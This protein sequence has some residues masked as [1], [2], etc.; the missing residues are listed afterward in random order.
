[1]A[2]KSLLTEAEQSRRLTD[3]L[4]SIFPDSVAV[5]DKDRWYAA[6]HRVRGQELEAVAGEHQTFLFNVKPQKWPSK[7]DHTMAHLKALFCLPLASSASSASSE[8]ENVIVISD[9]TLDLAGMMYG[10][11]CVL[12]KSD[13]RLLCVVSKPGAGVRELRDVWKSAPRCQLNRFEFERHHEA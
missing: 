11:S 1:M 5:C 2:S 6:G 10:M 12:Q 4:A 7:A 8:I 9:S 13:L 3:V